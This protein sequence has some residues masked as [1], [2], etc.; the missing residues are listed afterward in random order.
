M[1]EISK[2]GGY[3][4]ALELCKE[5][6]LKNMKESKLI[7]EWDSKKCKVTPEEHFD[8]IVKWCKEHIVSYVWSHR[9]GSKYNWDTS[10]G[11]KHV[12]ERELKCYVGNNWIKLAMIYAGIEVCSTK[13]VDKENG[14]VEKRPVELWEV[15][16]DDINF[17][18]RFKDDNK[19]KYNCISEYSKHDLNIR[20]SE[21]IKPF[22][23]DNGLLDYLTILQKNINEKELE[24]KKLELKESN[25]KK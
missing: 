21:D 7:E 20:W 18:C 23:D 1:I 25:L 9:T 10:Y 6:V 19:I 15:L 12:C 2:L 13:Y 8:N 5:L 3:E 17:I 16:C 24:L 11:A 4:K 14:K 22:Y